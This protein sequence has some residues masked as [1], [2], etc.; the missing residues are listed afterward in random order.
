MKRIITSI[1]AA[2]A[3]FAVNAQQTCTISGTIADN[4]LADGTKVKAVTLTRTDEFGQTIEVA[5]TKVKRGRYTFKHTLTD[6]TP[7]LQ[8]ILTGFGED[9]GIVLFVE[10]GTISIATPTAMYPQQSTVGGTP[11][12]DTYAQYRAIAETGAS[13]VAEQVAALEQHHGKEWLATTEGKSTVKRIQAMQTIKTETAILRFLIDHNASPMMPLEVERALLSKLTE[14]YA[15]QMVKAVSTTLHQHPYYH[16]LRNAVLASTLKVGNEVP[17]ITLPLLSGDIKH[18]VDYRGKYIIL[19]YWNPAD[20]Q[21]APLFAE[22]KNIYDV[23]KNDSKFHLLSIALTPDTAEWKQA[24][25][26]HGI[27]LPG[28]L[29]ACDGIGI[30]SPAAQRFKVTATPKIILIEPEGHAISLDMELNEVIM[31]I[32]QIMSGDLYYLDQKE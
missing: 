19:N 26:N 2:T 18:L 31:R 16:S 32:E 6:D 12:N 7:V 27:D 14:S 5:T 29:H 1:I 17:D 21:S 23:I 13:Q 15:D 20:E 9:Q 28:W 11:T 22:L 25:K 4:H 3:C 24:V 10:P 8:H 30:E